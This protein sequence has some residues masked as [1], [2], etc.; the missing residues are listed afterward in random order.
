MYPFKNTKMSLSIF[1][2][3]DI[4]ICITINMIQHSTFRH[5]SNNSA[6]NPLCPVGVKRVRSDQGATCRDQPSWCFFSKETL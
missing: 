1:I 3:T 6:T 2:A 5:K 4:N